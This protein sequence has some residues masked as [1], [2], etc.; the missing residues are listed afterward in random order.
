MISKT[1][2]TFE[3]NEIENKTISDFQSVLMQMR[4]CAVKKETQNK[5]E[6]I[7]ANLMTLIPEV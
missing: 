1:I 4:D 5:I 7:Y 2:E 3:L 6:N